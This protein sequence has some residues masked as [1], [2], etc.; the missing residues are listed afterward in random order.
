[1]NKQDCENALALRFDSDAGDNGTI[2]QYLY[3]LLSTLWEEEEGFSGK[4]PFGNSGW[5]YDL[6][7]PLIKAGILKGELDGDGFIQSCDNKKGK[8]IVHDLIHFVFH[9]TPRPQK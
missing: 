5:K 4:R 3:A 2:R 1:M 6:Y 9:E 7:G 8:E